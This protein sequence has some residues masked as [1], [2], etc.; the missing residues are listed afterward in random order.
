MRQR[1]VVFLLKEKNKPLT[2]G[3]ARNF[4]RE[5]VKGVDYLH[6]HGIIHRDLKLSNIL[7][8]NSMRPVLNILII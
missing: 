2:E 7:I 4:F 1:G 5:I 3:E 6:E 8:D